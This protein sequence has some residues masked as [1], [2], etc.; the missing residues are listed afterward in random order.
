MTPCPSARM[1]LEPIDYREGA[2]PSLGA[3]LES[4]GFRPLSACEF[5]WMSAAEPY[6]DHKRTHP[7]TC[8][9]AELGVRALDGPP[10]PT[11]LFSPCLPRRSAPAAS[12]PAGSSMSPASSRSARIAGP[13]RRSSGSRTP[14]GAGGRA[15]PAGA[16]PDARQWC[17]GVGGGTE[18]SVALAERPL[19]RNDGDAVRVLAVR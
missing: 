4:R 18:G 19:L 11:T 3:K 10:G 5:R 17:V 8:D 14:R 2:S 1:R 16:V 7:N 6:R 9:H 13:A 12:P 15:A